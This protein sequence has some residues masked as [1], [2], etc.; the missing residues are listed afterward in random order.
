MN[1]S[2]GWT[3]DCNNG[4][5]NSPN[6]HVNNGLSSSVRSSNAF[7]YRR[8][9]DEEPSLWKDR[10]TDM[11]SNIYKWHDEARKVGHCHQVH[12]DKTFVLVLLKYLELKDPTLRKHVLETIEDCG[13]RKQEGVPGCT[14]ISMARCLK[15]LVGKNCWEESNKLRYLLQKQ[16]ESGARVGLHPDH[17][18]RCL[19]PTQY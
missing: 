19:A 16:K 11:D 4:S 18:D 9:D 17:F 10:T 14:S 8:P 6:S 5:G 7:C 13:R 12:F 15:K 3:I 1:H 2:I